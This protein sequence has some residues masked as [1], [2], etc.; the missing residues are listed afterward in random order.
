MRQS[1]RAR[2]AARLVALET[3]RQGASGAR[4]RLAARLTAIHAALPSVPPDEAMARLVAGL[5]AAGDT[6]GIA[7]LR[8]VVARHG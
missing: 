2:L 4:E 6:P 8:R 5:A 7:G 3:R 1:D